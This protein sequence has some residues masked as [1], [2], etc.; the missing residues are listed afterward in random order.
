MCKEV[1]HNP[2]LQTEDATTITAAARDERAVC[3]PRRL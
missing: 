2:T 3:G 1:A